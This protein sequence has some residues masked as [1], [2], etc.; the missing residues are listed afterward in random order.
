MSKVKPVPEGHHTVAPYLVVDGA[1][2]AMEFYTRAFGAQELFRMPGPNGAIMHAE[3]MIGD[4]PVMLCDASPETGSQS[5]Q[6]LN[7]T[8]VSIFLYVPDVDGFVARATAAGATL[9]VPLTNMFWGDRY[10]QL[11]DPYGHVWQV[12][13]HVEDVAPDEMMRRATDTMG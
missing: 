1:A 13:T 6:S 12:A 9:K 3:I 10:A 11:A 8:P 4:S 7:G 5:P 2:A